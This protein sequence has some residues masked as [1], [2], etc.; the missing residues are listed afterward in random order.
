[1]DHS[2]SVSRRHVLSAGAVAGAS[3]LVVGAATPASAHVSSSAVLSFSPL[4]EGQDAS[5]A[6]QAAMEEAAAA[7]R[8]LQLEAGQFPVS[9]LH[10]PDGL[11]MRGVPGHTVLRLNGSSSLLKADRLQLLYMSSIVFDGK[12]RSLD[13]AYGLLDLRGVKN[14]NLDDCYITQSTKSGL[15]LENCGGRIENNHIT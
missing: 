2:S 3:G 13:D 6:L 7:G 5:A 15:Y 12:L 11:I 8:T 10:C 4:P 9:S 14:L 1:M